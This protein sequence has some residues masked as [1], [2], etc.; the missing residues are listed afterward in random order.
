MKLQNIGD[1]HVG[2][3]LHMGRNRVKAFLFLL[4]NLLT[5]ARPSDQ[6]VLLVQE[7]RHFEETT[8]A[9]IYECFDRMLG[10]LLN[11]TTRNYITPKEH[12]TILTYLDAQ[13]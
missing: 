8:G 3:L 7:F 4:E 11:S 2:K 1:A 10:A 9:S 5:A 13:R 6:T 12:T